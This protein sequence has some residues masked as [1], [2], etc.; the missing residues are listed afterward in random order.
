MKKNF[1]KILIGLIAIGLL[2]GC[3]KSN[4]T[5][6]SVK[7]EANVSSKTIVDPGPVLS[8]LYDTWYLSYQDEDGVQIEETLILEEGFFE[9]TSTYTEKGIVKL[10]TSKG[11]YNIDNSSYIMTID[12]IKMNAAEIKEAVDQ[13]AKFSETKYSF[14]IVAEVTD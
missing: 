2:A 5:N 12:E 14:D 4:K 9:L 10:A 6:S 8:E 1:S 3:V 11:T 13:L 7:L